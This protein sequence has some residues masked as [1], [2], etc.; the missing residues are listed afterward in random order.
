[1]LLGCIASLLSLKKDKDRNVCSIWIKSLCSKKDN[2][3]KILGILKSIW[4]L[5]T[6]NVA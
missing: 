4:K 5:H 1:M 2:D 3:V 6:I